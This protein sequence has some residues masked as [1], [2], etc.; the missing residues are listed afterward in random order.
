MTDEKTF[1]EDYDRNVVTSFGKP[2]PLII[3]QADD[4]F[5][6]DLKG[7]TY[8]DFWAGIATVNAGHNNPKIQRA[9]KEQL[10]RLVHCSSHSYY[11]LPALELAQKIAEVA[12]FKP[13]KS[14]FHTSGSE[15][16]DVAIK[17]VRRY[18]ENAQIT[19][20]VGACLQR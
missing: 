8:L 4:V 6:T 18:T 16:S 13:C 17:M 9:V 14:S 5:L 7:K 10:E 20:S 19:R 11:T 3:V 1:I 2:F 12:P 15:A